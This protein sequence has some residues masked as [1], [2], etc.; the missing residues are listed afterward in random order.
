MNLTDSININ[1]TMEM[2]IDAVESAS[3]DFFSDDGV[4]YRALIVSTLAI[5]SIAIV[6]NVFLMASMTMPLLIPSQRKEYSTYNIYLVFLILPDIAVCIYVIHLILT[7]HNR[8]FY[9]LIEEDGTIE[10]M[11]ENNRF[12]HNMFAMYVSSN[13]YTNDFLIYECYMLLKHS[14]QARRHKPPSILRVTKQAMVA[15]AMGMCAFVLEVIFEDLDPDR[16]VA[17]ILYQA[18]TY[19]VFAA[20]PLLILL[21]LW[22]KIHREGLT[23][24]TSSMFH[25]RLRVLVNYFA[26]IVLTYLVCSGIGTVSY[27]IYWTTNHAITQ[28]KVFC[29]LGFLFLVG[30][31]TMMNFVLALTKPDARTYAWN[32]VTCGCCV[33]SKDK[34]DEETVPETET[35]DPFLGSDESI[36]FKF[37]H[38]SIAAEPA[39]SCRQSKLLKALRLDSAGN[40]WD[41]AKGSIIDIEENP[42]EEDAD[43]SAIFAPDKETI[44]PRSS[45][46]R[47][48]D[49]ETIP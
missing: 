14:S 8:D 38:M 32:L 24:A 22:I 34:S 47:F 40:V 1:A 3:I 7:R 30:A 29:Y 4:A 19:L 10:W 43:L 12:D 46:V 13:L 17:Y 9:P 25:G 6:L 35:P 16:L 33:F 49:P 11:F 23:K 45:V 36:E 48:L 26:R 27:M 37:R 39:Q 41:S 21:A 5:S 44:P 42:K 28:K 20:T 18:S 31:Q 2:E 15:Y